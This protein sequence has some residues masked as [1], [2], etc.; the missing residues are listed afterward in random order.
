MKT[1]S[2][3][4]GV[5]YNSDCLN[6]LKNLPEKSIDAVITD[7]PYGLSDHNHSKIVDILKEWLNGNDS[8]VPDGKGFMGK[9]WDAFVPPPAV[10][11]EC[12]RTLKPGGHMLVFA[13]TRSVDL[14]GIS[15]RLAGFEIR[16]EI[17]WCYGSGFPKSLNVANTIAKREGAKRVGAGSKGNTFPLN[18]EYREYLLTKTAK[19]W[20]GWGTAL[21]PA[22]EPIILARKPLENGLNVAE[23]C[24]KWGTGG[25]NIDECR[26]ETSENLG[27]KNNTPGRF[28]ANLIHDGSK[29]IENCF[30]ETKRGSASRFFYK[31]EW[32]DEDIKAL[33]YCAK[34]NRR[35]RDIGLENLENKRGGTYQFRQDG[36]LDGQIPLKRNNHPTVKPI[37]LIEYL[38]KLT[39]REN[40]VVLDPFLGSGTTAVACKRI[41]RRFIGIEINEEYYNIAI[42]RI[43]SVCKHQD[44]FNNNTEQKEE[45]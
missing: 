26:I 36:S 18:S 28:P 14:M 4:D 43:S 10:W 15:L 5:I 21:K 16:D 22:H 25:L 1:F 9:D 40:Q 37:K 39:T 27:R 38:I 24:L 34:A 42:N 45:K 20:E 11:K 7:P 19:E 29:E 31:A 2:N 3:E 23:N 13:G 12:L 33:I 6:I 17:I 41:N 44:L 30:P 35:E 32:T 8:V